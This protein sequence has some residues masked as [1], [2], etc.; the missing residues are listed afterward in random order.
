LVVDRDVIARGGAGGPPNRTE[1]EIQQ[2]SSTMQAGRAELL[3]NV[4]STFR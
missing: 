2:C 3:T 4:Q 1:E